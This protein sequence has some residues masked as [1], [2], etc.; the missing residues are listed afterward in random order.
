MSFQVDTAFVKNYSSTLYHLVQQKGSRLRTAVRQEILNGEENYFDQIGSTDAL[1]KLARHGDSPAI[2]IPHTR[3]RVFQRDFEWGDLI[4]K[5][6]KIRLLIDP[7]SSYLQSAMWSLGR[8]IDDVLIDA[9]LG[10]AYTGKNGTISV[11]LPLTQKIPVN[12]SG[13]TLQKLFDA[14]ERLDAADVDPDEPRYIAVT[15]KQITNLLNTTEVKSSD[16]N[17]VRAL[18]QGQ[19]DSY[20]G[21]KFITTQRLAKD[22]NGDRQIIAWAQNG[23]L[24]A[25]GQDIQGQVAS[26]PD[27]SFSTYVYACLSCGATR[28]EEQKIIE[29]ACKE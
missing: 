7:A 17:T 29:I 9:A 23:L 6:D 3:R 13:L 16:Y 5:N 28:M 27:K 4:D 19:I 18:V 21:F 22:I 24:L 1:E 26:R 20:M 2:S 25:I 14:K 8:R 15:A 11:P 10:T 12:A